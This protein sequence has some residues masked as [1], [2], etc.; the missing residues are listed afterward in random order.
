MDL[1]GD[2]QHPSHSEVSVL[3]D[4]DPPLVDPER[5]NLPHP[6]HAKAS[7]KKSDV[8]LSGIKAVS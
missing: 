7:S 3:G 2:E 6:P 8:Q 5:C 1:T 4:T